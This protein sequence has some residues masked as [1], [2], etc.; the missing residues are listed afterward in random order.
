MSH[1]LSY[2]E[3]YE[4]YLELQ[5]R[6]T[7]FSATEQELINTRDRLDQELELYKRLNSFNNDAIRS[8][9]VNEFLQLAVE[10]I[11]DIL[12]VQGLSQSC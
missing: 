1:P 5:L 2:E 8:Q 4:Q 10:S 11:I 6:V 12:E 7:R 9:T 3:L